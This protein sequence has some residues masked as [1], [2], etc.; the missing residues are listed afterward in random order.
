MSGPFPV[1]QVANDIEGTRT[2]HDEELIFF[3]LLEG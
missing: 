1:A 2:T 3:Q